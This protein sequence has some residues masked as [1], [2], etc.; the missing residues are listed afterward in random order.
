[1][2]IGDDKA[3]LDLDCG[4]I[5]IAFVYVGLDQIA[6]VHKATE[7]A[8]EACCSGCVKGRAVA[9]GGCADKRRASRCAPILK[10]RLGAVEAVGVKDCHRAARELL[11][12]HRRIGRRK[13]KI[14]FDRG[15]GNSVVS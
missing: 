9:L 1:M 6:T 2:V 11:D 5:A 10:S 13:A 12:E 8:S 14:R 3:I 4:G 7:R 15:K